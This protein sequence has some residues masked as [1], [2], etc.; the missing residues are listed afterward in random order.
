ME[1]ANFAQGGVERK[2]ANP[3][4]ARAKICDNEAKQID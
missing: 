2:R 3:K 1:L 4:G